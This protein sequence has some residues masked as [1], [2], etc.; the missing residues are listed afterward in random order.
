MRP[1]AIITAILPVLSTVCAGKFMYLSASY[2][3]VVAR[4]LGMETMR[5]LW[6]GAAGA[7]G[8]RS[9]TSVPSA[10]SAAKIRLMSTRNTDCWKYWEGGR[11]VALSSLEERAV[12]V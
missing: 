12:V 11:D 6:A 4:T 10:T 8:L 9:T 2:A 7:S 1:H 3:Q 5:Y